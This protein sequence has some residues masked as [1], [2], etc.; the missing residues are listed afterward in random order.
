[1][2]TFIIILQAII[3]LSLIIL[4]LM[5]AKGVGLGKAWG[6]TGEFYKNRRGVEKVVFRATIGVAILFFAVSLL[7]LLS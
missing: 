5:Q 7:S 4:I 6:G 2:S 1:M 3:S